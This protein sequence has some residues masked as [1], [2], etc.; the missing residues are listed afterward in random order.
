MGYKAKGTSGRNTK[1]QQAG[2][3]NTKGVYSLTRNPLYLGN[4]FI[5]WGP[6]IY[7]YS[8]TLN[9]IYIALFALHYE[10]II[11]A[12]ESYLEGKFGD[13]YKEWADKT[14]IF[15]PKLSGFI[16]SDRPFSRFYAFYQEK[17][18]IVAAL[19]SFWFVGVMRAG[20]T[21]LWL[22]IALIL[23]AIYYAIF[24]V[25]GKIIKNGGKN[26]RSY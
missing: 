19:L 6:I 18:A 3:L 13:V 25:V 16:A 26:L 11:I 9:P 2:A 23:G 4:F 22:K 20:N 14:P 12:E 8:W 7:A 17:A 15:F 10:R 21:E 5:A 1:A 24:Y